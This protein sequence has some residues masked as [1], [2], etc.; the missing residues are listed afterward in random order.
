M[1][2]CWPEKCG[3]LATRTRT[4]TPLPFTGD[5]VVSA[6]QGTTQGVRKQRRFAPPLP[7]T[8]PGITCPH[9]RICWT[10]T[11]CHSWAASS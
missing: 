2:R 10:P 7:I 1:S 3:L 11:R 9:D 8:L 6:V 5:A 4:R